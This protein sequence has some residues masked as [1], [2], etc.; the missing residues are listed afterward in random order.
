VFQEPKGYYLRGK[1][2]LKKNQLFSNLE[3]YDFDQQSLVYLGY[4][5]N[6]GELKIDLINMEAKMKWPIPTNINEFRSFVGETQ[7]L[8]KFITYFSMLVAPFHAITSSG[9]SFHWRKNQQ[10]Y[11]NKLKKKIIQALV[12]ILP[13]L[14]NPFEVETDASGC[15]VGVVFIQGGKIVFYNS[16]MFHGRV[17]K[18]PTY[19]KELYTLGQVD[20]NWKH[21]LIGKETIIHTDQ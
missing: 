17:Q 9:K 13:Y 14:Q 1:W 7:Y 10:K 16:K 18:Y 20:N 11:F 2:T 6:G 4:M 3:K 19:D 21:Y 8:K 5:I 12:L 15:V